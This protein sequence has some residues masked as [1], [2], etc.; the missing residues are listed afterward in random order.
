[1]YIFRQRKIVQLHIQYMMMF[2]TR[3]YTH[4]YVH[5]YVCEYIR[6][7]VRIRMYSLSFEL[8]NR[9]KVGARKKLKYN[10]K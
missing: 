8:T 4:K 1:M 5:T 10:Y 3:H 9:Q 2:Y 7:H 6:I